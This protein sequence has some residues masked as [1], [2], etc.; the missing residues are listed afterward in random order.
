M[1]VTD[2]QMEAIGRLK[3]SLD[4][5]RQVYESHWSDIIKYLAPSYSSM[6]VGKPGTETVPSWE[7][8]FDTL[9]IYSSNIFADGLQGYAF[10]RTVSWFR[11]RFEIEDL[12]KNSASKQWLQSVEKHLYR[13]FNNSN[14]YDEA[15][16]FLRCGA[17]FGTAVMTYEHDPVR[18]VPVFRSLHP[19]SYSIEEDK[20]GEVSTLIRSFWLSRQDAIDR[21]GEENLPKQILTND[22]DVASQYEF[23]QYVA[24]ETR[25]KVDIAGE[26]EFVSVY[27]AAVDAKKP[28]KEER[29][30]HKPFFAWRWA[31]NPCGSPWGVDNPGMVEISGIKMLQGLK[32]DMVRLSQLT[33]RPPVKRTEGLVINFTPSGITDI[34][35]GADFAPVQLTGDL[36]WTAQQIIFI[37]QQ[38]KSSYHVDF[39]LALM[40][41]QDRQKT[42]TEV[43]ALVDEK[44]AIMSAFFSRLSHEF[45]EPV[46]EAMFDTEVLSMRMPTPPPE[47]AGSALKIDFVSPLA[48]LQKRAHGFNTTKQFLAEILAMAEISPS[49]L[50]KVSIDKYVEIAAESYDVDEGVIVSDEEVKKIREARAQMQM[51]QIQQQQQ[52]EQAKANA[53]V[54]GATSKA[55][56]KGSPAESAAKGGRR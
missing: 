28:I 10:G 16:A 48:M 22:E 33:G 5:Y 42:A 30:D 50:D 14:F 25:I 32:L 35:P 40:S 20:Y 55:P 26:G 47:G 11:L 21:F 12:M 49:I 8:I 18:G 31:K 23:F 29:F 4:S 9:P 7:P 51:Q 34:T 45:I 13:Q 24:P 17:D 2:K 39:F 3:S 27:W 54:Y 37:Q 19:G 6:R 36:S 53:Q 41:M 1:A 38:I 46:L 43:Q 44:S 56:E 15:R 52:V